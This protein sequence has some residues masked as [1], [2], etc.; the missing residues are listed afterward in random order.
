MFDLLLI[1][2]GEPFLWVTPFLGDSD[3]ENA[4]DFAGKVAAGVRA[5]LA[6]VSTIDADT[7]MAELKLNAP[8]VFADVNVR[9]GEHYPMQ[10]YGAPNLLAAIMQSRPG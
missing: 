9:T 10:D 8:T 5:S 1:R 3:E 4:A 7:L 2:G 6:K